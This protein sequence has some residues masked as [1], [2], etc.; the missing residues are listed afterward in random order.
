MKML[1]VK[2]VIHGL[3]MKWMHLL[4]TDMGLSWSCFAWPKITVIILPKLFGGLCQVLEADLHKLP[5]F[6]AGML[7]SY[8]KVNDLYYKE[9]KKR[10]PTTESLGHKGL[11]FYPPSVEKT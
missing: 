1:H 2:N 10:F 9:N 3:R 5:P 8:S 7:C 11:S 6:Y 4:T